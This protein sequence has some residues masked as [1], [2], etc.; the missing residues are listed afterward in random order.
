MR[1]QCAVDS[2]MQ[3]W[4]LL[5]LTYTKQLCLCLLVCC[6]LESGNTEISKSVS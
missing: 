6:L 4:G 2:H 1:E 3:S 5:R